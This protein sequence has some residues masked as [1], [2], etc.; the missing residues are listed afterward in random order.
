MNE[1]QKAS[2]S[3]SEIESGRKGIKFC[4]KF[5]YI[6]STYR[7]ASTAVGHMRLALVI[8][9]RPVELIAEMYAQ[10]ACRP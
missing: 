10:S 6:R 3:Q 2:R 8:M 9:G 4:T 5:N 1:L 7:E